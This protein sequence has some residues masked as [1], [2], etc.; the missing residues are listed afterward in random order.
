MIKVCMCFSWR[1]GKASVKKG[2]V[3]SSLYTK[4][5]PP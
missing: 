4:E 2:L 5:Y 3:A 1:A